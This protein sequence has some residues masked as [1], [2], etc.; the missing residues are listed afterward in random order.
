MAF[1]MNFLAALS[2]TDLAPLLADWFNDILFGVSALPDSWLLSRLTFLPKVDVPSLP[3]HLRPIV[4]SSTP[5]K[6]FTKILLFRLRPHFPI[7]VA[8]QLACIPGC[9]TLDGSACLQHVIHLSQEYKL[10]LVAIKLD[11]ASAFDHLSHTSIARFLSLCG[12]HLESH[13]LLRIITLS[14]VLISISDVSWEQK[15]GRGVVQGSS[16]SAELFA[17]TLDFY[18]GAVVSKWKSS[19]P[20]W[21]QSMDPNGVFHQLYNLLF[22]DDIVLL[23]TSFE[24]ASRMLVDV[25][26]AL[27]AIGLTLALDKCKYISSPDLPVVPLVVRGIDIR[28]VSSFRFLGILMGFGISSQTILSARLTQAQNSFWGYFKILKRKTGPLKT[29]LHLLNT[30]VTSKWRWLS[31]CVR[32]VTM[33]SNMLL[34]VQTTLL[35]SLC[36]FSPDPFITLSA[37]WTCRRRASRMCAQA[38]GQ[39]TWSGI[40]A[41][42][43]LGYWGHAARLWNFRFSP[44][45][46]A[47]GIRDG[48]WLQAFQFTL[49][50]QRGFWP[51]CYRF[52]Q[53]AWE[54]L[55]TPSDP[56]LWVDLAQDR[57]AW[58]EFSA[59]WLR[60]KRLDPTCFYPDLTSVDLAGRCLLQVGDNFKLLPFRHVP[61]EQ[62]YNTSFEVIPEP[63]ADSDFGC[64]QV[65]SDGGCRRGQGSL[66]VSILAPYAPLEDAILV[67]QKIQGPCTNNKAELLAAVQALKHIRTLLRFFPSIPFVYMSDSMLVIQALEEL[68]HI[69]CHPS[70]VHELLSL[71]R[72]LCVHGKAI[73]VRGHQG[74]PQ[75]TLTDKAA[76]EALSFS[77]SLLQHRKVD[78]RH[79][80][81]TQAGQPTP[82]FHKFL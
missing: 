43:F 19:E 2:H 57:T 75:N 50:R 37:N 60:F 78:F 35:T 71:W 40:H 34:I 76:T 58:L 69:T 66:A 5:A 32:P 27:S 1:H 13:V 23:A 25:I 56:W 48:C 63:L 7:P 20:T 36:G 80:Y 61:V 6:V 12:P 17:R 28:P 64:F 22:A 72:Q 3:K 81:L 15:L 39:H 68:S 41:K 33:V 67:Q 82:P 49:R 16:Y 47:L 73:H 26:D 74:H 4:L 38:L 18:L 62:P 77:H 45:T 54:S 65:C 8:N 24:Q 10:P 44:I 29:R 21:I 59:L 9:Q 14:R 30:F 53:L 46:V 52:L 42:T 79:V 11:A 70:I 31:P 55:R 51:N